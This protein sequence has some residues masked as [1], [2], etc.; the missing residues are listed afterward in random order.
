MNKVETQA[1]LIDAI[2][3]THAFYSDAFSS[4]LQLTLAIVGFFGVLMPILVTWHQ[5][6]R[7]KRENESLKVDLERAIEAIAKLKFDGAKDEIDQRFHSME[8]GFEARFD[9][10][11]SKVQAQIC[12]IDAKAFLLQAKAS[13]ASKHFDSAVHSYC[14]A[15]INFLAAAQ[16]GNARSATVGL[17]AALTS[18]PKDFFVDKPKCKVDIEGALAALRLNDSSGGFRDCIEDVETELSKALKR[19]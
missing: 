3:A 13:V 10:L 1:N 16:H 6:I 8:R 2:S 15:I 7:I 18:V 4:L 17:T 5:S 19:P 11:D 14:T 12:S 9:G